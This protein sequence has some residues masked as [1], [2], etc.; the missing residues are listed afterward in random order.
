VRAV[1]PEPAPVRASGL[2][3]PKL[4]PKAKGKARTRW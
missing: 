2:L 4:V 3:E 1:W